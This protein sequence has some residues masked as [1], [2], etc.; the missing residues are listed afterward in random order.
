MS[1]YRCDWNQG[2]GRR[3]SFGSSHPRTRPYRGTLLMRNR[4]PLGPY[5]GE[6]PRA[7]WRPK[8]EGAVSYERGTPVLP[9]RPA[10]AAVG[11]IQ[12]YL[13]H[14]K[15]PHPLGPP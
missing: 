7:L 11:R 2:L 15:Q 3:Q 8:G 10:R 14:N 5:S 9:V 4:P 6:M 13:A 12:G 1:V